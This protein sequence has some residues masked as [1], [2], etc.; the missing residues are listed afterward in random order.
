MPLISRTLLGQRLREL[1]DSGV[2][3]SKPLPSRGREYRLTEAGEEF[4]EVVERLGAWGQRHGAK[5]FVL[6]NL[7]PQLL[8][9][10]MHRHIDVAH[11]PQERVVVQF[12][13]R[14][15]PPRCTQMRTCW[16]VLEKVGVDVCMR[17]PG[18]EVDLRVHADIGAL[19]RV[20]V[21]RVPF[22]QAV[23]SGGIRLEGPKA[24]VRAFP[25][26]LHLS[27]FARVLRQAQAG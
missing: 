6:D 15:V 10:A 8:M 14:G 19:A 11:L 26:W 9:W 20:W 16:L 24:L 27:P 7:D 18:Y 5:Q 1:E 22:A 21:G 25:G 12:E 2:I 13:L 4:R 3:A 23:R 17:D